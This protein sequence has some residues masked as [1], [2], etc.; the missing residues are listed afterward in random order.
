LTGELSRSAKK[1]Q[2]VLASLKV[3]T[4]V[5]ELPASARTAAEAAS[6]IGCSVAQIAKTILFRT[7]KEKKPIIVVAS[8]A[9]RINEARIE[10]QI[11]E[12]IEK[13]DAAYV[14]EQ[15][16]FVI[17]GVPPIA[18]LEP[19]YTIVDEDLLGLGDI[20]A[21]AGTPN[22][23]FRLTGKALLEMT[24]GVLMPIK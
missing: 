20:W 5:I 16:G 4:E 13:A 24:S 21:A 23:V 9:N 1:V 15:T 11:G 17:G 10:A 14:R 8:G 18:H 6:A 22:A 12:P 3:D 19:I 7:M 2:D